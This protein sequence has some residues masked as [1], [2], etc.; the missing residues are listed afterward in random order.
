[1]PPGLRQMW[2]MIVE[3]GFLTVMPTI[4]GSYEM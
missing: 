4:I 1:M 2:Q 3:D